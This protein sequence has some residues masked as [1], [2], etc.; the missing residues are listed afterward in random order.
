MGGESPFGC[1]IHK[2][3]IMILIN[4]DSY[5]KNYMWEWNKEFEIYSANNWICNVL[6]NEE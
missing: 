6:N 4:M 5:S 2:K 1:M 3:V